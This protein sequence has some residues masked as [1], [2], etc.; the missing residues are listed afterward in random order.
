MAGIRLWVF[1]P[2]VP[3]SRPPVD[4]PPRYHATVQAQGPLRVYA[5]EGEGGRRA[6]ESAERDVRM[7]TDRENDARVPVSEEQ[8]VMDLATFGLT[9]L[10]PAC[11]SPS[12]P[13]CRTLYVPRSPGLPSLL[14]LLLLLLLLTCS[15]RSSQLL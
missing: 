2:I 8:D 15:V 9:N 7:T 6:G 5:S 10:P 14:L 4:S 11:T 13:S 3:S 12:S 1:V